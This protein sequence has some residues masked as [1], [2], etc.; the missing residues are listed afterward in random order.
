M[1]PGPPLLDPHAALRARLLAR[2][3]EERQRRSRDADDDGAEAEGPARRAEERQRRVREADDGDA[4]DGPSAG[5]KAGRGGPPVHSRSESD[6]V[7]KWA[8]FD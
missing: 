4:E 2:R 3:E 7:D 1:P 6:P 8:V 5:R